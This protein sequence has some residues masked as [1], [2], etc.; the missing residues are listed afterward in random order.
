[1][2][3][4]EP[5]GHWRE[6]FLAFLRL[7]CIAFGGPVA[8]LGYFREAFVDRRR[9]LDERAYGELVALAQFLPGPASSQVGMALGLT[10]AGLPGALAAWLGFTLPSALIMVGVAAG[11]VAAQDMLGSGWLHGLKIAAVAVVARALWGMASR[12]CP[13]ASRASFAVAAAVVVTALPGAVGQ[14]GAIALAA[15][16]GAL[17]LRRHA[18]AP[19][20]SELPVPLGRATGAAMLAVFAVLLAALPALA[21]VAD[22]TWLTI[23]DAAYRAGALVFGG[24]HVVLP[25]LQAEVVPTGLLDRASFLAGYGA[26]QALPG[27]LFTF[28]GY[29]GTA[30]G[31]AA[32]ALAGLIG[33]FL[34]G[35]LL[36]LGALPFWATLRRYT[37]AAAALTGVN[38]GVVGLL[39]AALHDPVWTSTIHRPA[40]FAVALTAFLLLTAWRVP[41]AVVVGLC[42]LAGGGLAAL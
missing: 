37:T 3:R 6:V 23:A 11:F 5:D 28:G 13:D 19:E 24:G 2:P 17:L 39:A 26:A 32:G 25:L 27:P 4:A 33:I 36:M 16:G 15:V 18:A 29:L 41:P 8:H 9:W 14:L 7:G 21:A 35:F 12:L 40:D 10:R 22:G 1:M 42:A 20:A 34:P 38:A 30:I 31:G